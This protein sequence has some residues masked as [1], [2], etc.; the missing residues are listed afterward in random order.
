MREIKYDLSIIIPT[1]NVGKYII[2]TMESI[3]NQKT[4]FT[5]QIIVI[6]DGSTDDTVIKLK[7]FEAKYVNIMIIQQENKGAGA[8]RNIGLEFSKGR[9][10]FFCDSDDYILPE[11][12]QS[13]LNVMEKESLEIFLYSAKSFYDNGAETIEFFPTYIRPVVNNVSGIHFIKISEESKQYFVVPTM[14]FIRRDFLLT[15]NI[16]FPEGIIYEDIYFITVALLKANKVSSTSNIFY[17]RRIRADSVM[18]SRDKKNSINSI[19]KL[20]IQLSE[21]G[22]SEYKNFKNIN[23][24]DNLFLLYNAEYTVME[25]EEKKLLKQ[26]KDYTTKNDKVHII[27]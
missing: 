16:R 18:T 25:K 14:F 10:I 27:V 7:K 12:I 3:L 23:I 6:D 5:F 13:C 15:N 9:Y 4:R 21:Y 8:A 1:Y 19:G 11:M 20:I 22:K 24:L 17:M 2:E 26:Q